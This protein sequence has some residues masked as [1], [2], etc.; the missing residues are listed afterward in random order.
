MSVSMRVRANY[1]NLVILHSR[2]HN[3]GVVHAN[4]QKY[5]VLCRQQGLRC[6]PG[7]HICIDM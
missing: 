7:T 2:Y 6:T 3:Q 4:K 1:T 5:R